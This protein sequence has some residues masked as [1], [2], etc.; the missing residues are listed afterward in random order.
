ALRRVMIAE[1]APIG[2]APPE[3]RSSSPGPNRADEA[4]G[5]SK[6]YLADKHDRRCYARSAA[7]R[8]DRRPRGRRPA[9]RPYAHQ[10]RWAKCDAQL[11]STERDATAKVL[12]AA[13]RMTLPPSGTSNDRLRS[14]TAWASTRCIRPCGEDSDESTGAGSRRRPP[15]AMARHL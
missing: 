2:V 15:G 14:F 9:K 11:R 10:H 13:T 12:A 3:S 8:T 1:H 7:R 5:I 4:V 6:K